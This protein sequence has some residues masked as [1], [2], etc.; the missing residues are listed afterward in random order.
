MPWRLVNTGQ[1]GFCC[2]C[3]YSLFFCWFLFVLKTSLPAY[4]KSVCSRPALSFKWGAGKVC[5]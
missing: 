2:Y 4:S 5:V 1:S 3:V